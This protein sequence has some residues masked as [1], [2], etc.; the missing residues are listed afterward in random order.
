MYR[1]GDRVIQSDYKAVELYRKACNRNYLSGC[2]WLGWMYQTGRGI[3][4]NLYE[5]KRLY[6]KACDKKDAEGC[7]FLGNILE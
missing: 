7:K 3:E 1:K 4:K 2:V 6:K 5:A